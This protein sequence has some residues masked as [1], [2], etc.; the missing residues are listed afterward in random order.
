MGLLQLVP[1]NDGLSRPAFK[2]PS[3]LDTELLLLFCGGENVVQGFRFA[4]LEVMAA[5]LASGSWFDAARH[6][7]SP[8]LSCVAPDAATMMFMAVTWHEDVLSTSS[9]E[10]K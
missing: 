6:K 1:D 10:T 2:F 9:C 8:S 3:L 5:W 4:H 7:V